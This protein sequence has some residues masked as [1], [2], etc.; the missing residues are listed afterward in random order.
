MSHRFRL[1]HLSDPHLTDPR[2]RLRQLCSK[3]LLGWLSWRLRRRREHRP[4][5]LAALVADLRRQNPDHTVVTGDL[6][7]IGLPHECREAAA[8]LASLGPPAQVSVIPGNH[9]R[10]VAE[11][12]ADTLARWAP[13][14]QG[15]RFPFVKALGAVRLIGLDSAPPTAP[16]LAT[17]ALGAAQCRRLETLLAETQGCRIVAIHHPPH[18]EA[19]KARKRLTDRDRLLAVLR[20]HRCELVL[21]GHTHHWQLHWLEGPTGPIPCLGVPS[22]S[23]LGRRRGYRA[24]YHL[25]DIEA[26]ADG[27]RIS[28]E[29]RGLDPASRAFRHEGSFQ[30]H[31]R[32]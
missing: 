5:V 11:N 9:D 16:F 6:T 19:A 25:Y 32:S 31:C 28:V 20:R 23:A 15:G 8:W 12:E 3:R 24:R 27:W 4:E 14:C 21:H 22:A 10:Y 17:G 7:Q 1:A 26:A 2:P 13:Y 29:I 18:P 30:L